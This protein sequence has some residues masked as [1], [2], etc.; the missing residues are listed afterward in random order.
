MDKRGVSSPLEIVACF[1]SGRGNEGNE[2]LIP[3]LSLIKSNSECLALLL[4]TLSRCEIES[5]VNEFFYDLGVEGARH[6]EQFPLFY[7]T[8]WDNL[9]DKRG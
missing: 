4:D 8:S 6:K 1:S 5:T 7:R 9:K 2:D 3:S